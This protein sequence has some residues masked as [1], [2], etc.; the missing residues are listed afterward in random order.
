MIGGDLIML[1]S[2][3]SGCEESK[4]VGDE[5]DRTTCTDASVDGLTYLVLT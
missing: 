5:G 3:E 4:I 2:N 1:Y